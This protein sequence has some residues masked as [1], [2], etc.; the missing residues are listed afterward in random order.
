MW[1]REL[2]EAFSDPAA[3]LAHLGLDPVLLPDAQ[4][5][6]VQFPL[7]AP[8]YYVALMQHGDAADPL[9]RQ[10]LPLADEQAPVGGFSLDPV[11]DL[12]ARTGSGILH[13]YRG[14]AL[15]ITTG[16][17]AVHCRYCFRR[18][19]PYAEDLA[20]RNQWQSV[21][22]ELSTLPDI[23]EV[24]LSG[25]DPL[26]L[27]DQRL[28]PLIAGLDA[29]P[30]LKRLRIH[31]RQPVVLPSRLTA[32]LTAMLSSS[33]LTTSLVL[34]ANHPREVTATLGDALQP[35]RQAGITLLNQAVLLAGVNDSLPTQ[36]ALAEQ[37]FERGVLPYYLHQLD[38]VAGAAHFQV[39]DAQ[40]RALHIAMRDYLPGYLLPR[41]VCEKP[42]AP[43][44]L[45]L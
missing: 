1:Q 27:S 43:A 24:I 40:A 12:A 2:A 31:S 45:P 35:L 14:R 20:S 38:P 41:L 29:L 42:G 13:K 11:G 33:R 21:L 23:D 10:V 18:H 16:A 25:G 37:L 32:E 30:Q 39:P 17:C 8:R 4:R 28:A 26:S 36:V 44:K 6:A 9:L 34:H 22:A 3:L 5:A 7:R 19:Y 15:L